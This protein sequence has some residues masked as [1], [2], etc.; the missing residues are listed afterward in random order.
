M[1]RIISVLCSLVILLVFIGGC[2]A[3]GENPF[4]ADDVIKGQ[5]GDLYYVIPGNAVVDESSTDVNNTYRVPIANSMEE[6]VL[7]IS[8]SPVEDT[9]EASIQSME[10]LREFLISSIEGLYEDED[11]T[12][13]LGKEVDYGFK[14][15]VEADGR[16]SVFIYALISQKLYF[17]GYGAKTGFYDQSVW[18]N[19]Y[20]QLKFV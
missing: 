19:F 20:A 14:I 12:D 9:Y 17:V 3:A 7:N 16:K 11:I 8:Y 10:S 6:Y 4:T 15:S 1:K 5:I 18:D 2:G 13:F